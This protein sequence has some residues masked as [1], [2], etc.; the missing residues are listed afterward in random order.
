M[1]AIDYIESLD[2]EDFRIE[3][4]R[5]KIERLETLAENR[6]SKA[7]DNDRVQTSGGKDRIGDLAVKIL[8]EKKRLNRLIDEK[9]ERI[10]YIEDQLE[11]IDKT[12]YAKIIFYRYVEKREYSEIAEMF[13]KSVQTIQNWHSKALKEFAR[14][15]IVP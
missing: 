11:K 1:T 9:E 14:V 3:R 10:E 8:E 2:K 15:F 4:C 12:E 6:T 7:Y 5:L 13:E